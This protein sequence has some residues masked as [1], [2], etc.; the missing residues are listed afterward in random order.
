MTVANSTN[1]SGPYAGAGTSGP[2]AVGFPF[3]ADS[4][5]LV[6]RTDPSG[7][8][9][10]LTLNVDYTVVGAGQPGGGQVTLLVAL[11]LSYTLTIQRSV[12]ITQELDYTQSDSFPA[13]SHEQGLDKLTMIAQQVDQKANRAIRIPEQGV[14]LPELPS[15][16]LRA[17]KLLSFD[18]LG[19]PVAAAAAA[20]TATALALALAASTGATLVSWIQA[21]TGAVARLVQDKL[22]ERLSV[23]DFG[24]AG[25]G[26]TDDTIAF[27]SAA[28]LGKLIRLRD[29]G[30]YRLS[31]QVAGINGTRFFCPG[32]A[33]ITVRTG[34]GFFNSTDLTASKDAAARCL[35]LFQARDDVGIEGVEI[36]HDG[37]AAVV[38]PIRCNGGTATRGCDFKRITFRN[39][40]I[41]NAGL[42]ALNTIGI[43]GYRVEDIAAY[44]CG[45]SSTAWTGTPQITV[46]EIDNDMLSSV[47]SQPGFAKNIRGVNIAFTGAALTLYGQQTDVVN[48]AGVSGTDRKGPTIIGIYGDNV[49]EVL[50]AFCSHGVFKGI[51]ARA[52]YN[53]G[54]KLIHGAQY[55]QVEC[56]S[57]ESFGQ[58]AITLSGSNAVAAHTAHNTIRVGVIR[59]SA[60]IGGFA[61]RSAVLFQDNGGTGATC[62]PKSNVVRVDKI[63]GDATNMVYAVRDGGAAN[64]NG[65][66]VEVGQ[67]SG[68][69][70]AS[71]SI[72]TPANV[73]V[74]WIDNTDVMMRMPSNQVVTSA[75]QTT[76]NFSTVVRDVNSEYT[77]GGVIR[78]KYP[79]KKAVS[80]TIRWQANAV[81]DEVLLQLYKNTTIIGSTIRRAAQNAQPETYTVA[82]V[83]YL[84]EDE[85]NAATAD[86]SVRATI[87]AGGTV[88][89]L[90]TTGYTQFQ[91]VGV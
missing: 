22:R 49:G 61:N 9:S 13:E 79:G 51:R 91:V 44:D 5:L 74:R 15:A 12:P 77:S 68:W 58:A 6:V 78:G 21:G 52:A 89:I 1:R 8:E 24:A 3:L 65:N 54:V 17:N 60:A 35:F 75:V 85:V 7:V 14:T 19:V 76:V 56:D 59:Q 18:A 87:T 16:A 71:T 39:F 88:T 66:L 27:Q 55:N 90:A 48:V 47:P 53:Y 80:A 43:G 41:C 62:L 50:D 38:Y 42:L 20:G 67:G 32:Q 25:D 84:G 69:V 63:I 40:P 28:A 34:V 37:G 10:S 64:A 45:T 29:G 36:V 57:I 33:K 83:D 81:G 26:V 73:R 4:H 2:F 31:G 70:T 23:E 30:N 11:P 46:F 86:Y 82:T 72:V